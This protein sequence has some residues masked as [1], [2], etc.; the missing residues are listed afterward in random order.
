[1]EERR[2]QLEGLKKDKEENK[3][4]KL[5]NKDEDDEDSFRGRL[6][7]KVADEELCWWFLILLL[8]LLQLKMKTFFHTF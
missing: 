8:Y 6:N 3:E 4:R 5:E 2:G 7:N 1:M